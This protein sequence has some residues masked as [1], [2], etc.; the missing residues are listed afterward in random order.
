M[1]RAA[2]EG[3]PLLPAAGGSAGPSSPGLSS[4]G[5]VFIL[6]KSALGAGLLSF[7]W[8]FG[9]AGGAVPALLVELVRGTRG[10]GAAAAPEGAE[11][12]RSGDGAEGGDAPALVLGELRAPPPCGTPVPTS[13][14]SLGRCCGAT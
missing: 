10:R 9:R 6:L 2:G 4:A 5:A 8:A 1:E 3:R 12:R 14:T 13:A 7:P 11:G